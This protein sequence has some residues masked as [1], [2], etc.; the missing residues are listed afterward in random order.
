MYQTGS[1]YL[2]PKLSQ[3]QPGDGDISIEDV[4]APGKISFLQERFHEQQSGCLEDGS[5]EKER[6][7]GEDNKGWGYQRA[8]QRGL[9]ARTYVH[10]YYRN[11][12]HLWPTLATGHVRDEAYKDYE[13]TRPDESQIIEIDSDPLDNDPKYKP[14]VLG[15]K[16]PKPRH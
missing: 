5:S 3:Q 9:N 16:S 7:A 8:V 14:N 10:K 1:Y 4:R 12:H 13:A 6:Y 11:G 15:L 2:R